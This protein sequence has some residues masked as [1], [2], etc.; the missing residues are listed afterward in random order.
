MDELERDTQ[1]APEE[2]HPQAPSLTETLQHIVYDPKSYL[3]G[4]ITEEE[5]YKSY[6]VF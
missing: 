5:V 6:K 3:L 4:D 2:M 1:D